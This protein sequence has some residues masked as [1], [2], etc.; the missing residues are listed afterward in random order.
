MYCCSARVKRRLRS[1]LLGCMLLLRVAHSA[2]R[3]EM[4]FGAFVDLHDLFAAQIILVLSLSLCLSSHLTTLQ[5]YRLQKHLAKRT[6]VG[7]SA[8]WLTRA[9]L[10]I[11]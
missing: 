5:L 1:E 6:A 7:K 2:T 8:S 10:Q 9:R 11:F 4:L 3:A